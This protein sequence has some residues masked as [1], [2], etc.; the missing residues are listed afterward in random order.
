[1]NVS[2]RVIGIGRAA[3]GAVESGPAVFTL[4]ARIDI[5]E[6]KGIPQLCVRNPVP[7][8]AHLIFGIVYKLV[9]GI[10]ITRGS[11]SQVFRPGTASRNSLI[12]AG[13]VLQIEHIVVKRD[14]FSLALPAQH[15]FCKNLI[16]FKDDGKV[17]LSQCGGAVRIRDDRLHGEFREAQIVGHMENILGKIGVEV[18]KGAAHV[19]ALPAA[20]VNELLEIGNDPVIA[21]AAGIV[22]AE[23]I[24]DLFAAVQAQDHVVALFVGP[25][26][27]L[28]G[29]S[30]AVCGQ[31]KTEILV[32]FF[33]NGTRIGDQLFTDFK[34]NQ[35]FPAEKV[36]LQI[37]AHS[38]IFHQKI[39]GSFPCLKSHKTVLSVEIALGC[40][41]V[42]AVEVAGVG[43]QQA[44]GLDD[45]ISLLEIKC[46][47]G[48]SLFGKQLSRSPQLP[49]ILEAF[50]DLRIRNPL[51]LSLTV[52]PVPVFCQEGLPDLLRVH[53]LVRHADGIVGL[54]VSDMDAAA[55]HIQNN[56]VAI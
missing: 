14:R 51:P 45:C 13:P 43:D 34:V 46:L 52:L 30:D 28:I 7:D 36:D 41:A 18:G 6:F 33:F 16:L 50:G 12:N 1:M 23:T 47:V 21:S 27:D 2:G 44:Q 54:L 17:L 29:D 35:G 39:Q 53:A 15:V 9:A 3:A 48:K 42:A 26:D 10:E 40:K 49:D 5:A 32:F 55:V 11:H 24:V 20:P 25:L 19:V 37:A 56:M 38:G 22:P 31:C 4:G 8:I